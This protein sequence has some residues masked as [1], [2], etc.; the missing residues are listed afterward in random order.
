MLRPLLALAALALSACA[1][2]ETN[3]AD[4][5]Y[6]EPVVV[7]GSHVPR[8]VT[9]GV[10]SIDGDAIRAQGSIATNKGTAGGKGQQ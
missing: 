4:K 10:Q 2:T 9:P 8:K 5:V 6:E 3:T 7:T 1:S